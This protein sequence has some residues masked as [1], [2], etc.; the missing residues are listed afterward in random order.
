MTG[1]QTC[2]LPIYIVEDKNTY[3]KGYC[4]LQQHNKGSVVQFRNLMFKPLK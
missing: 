4:A 1:A 3:T 2:A